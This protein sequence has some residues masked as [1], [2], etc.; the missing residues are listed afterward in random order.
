MYLCNHAHITNEENLWFSFW[1]WPKKMDD[2]KKRRYKLRCALSTALY[3][4]G[5]QNKDYKLF[6]DFVNNYCGT[7][8]K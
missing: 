2:N 5:K 7:P 3:D 1:K 8:Q 6:C 4:F